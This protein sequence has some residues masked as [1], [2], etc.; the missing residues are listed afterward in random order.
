MEPPKEDKKDC[1]TFNPSLTIK[2]L[3]EETD[4]FELIDYMEI[5]E[6]FKK[7]YLI[8][9]LSSLWESLSSR[10]LLSKQGIPRFA[11]IEV[12]LRLTCSSPVSRGSS[13]SASSPSSALVR[14][15]FCR[16]RSSWT[17]HADCST[18]TSTTTWPSCSASSTSTTMASSRKRTSASCC[19]TCHLPKFCKR[20]K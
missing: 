11:F 19:P 16:R 3:P 17:A 12:A 9:Y 4:K 7:T 6:S 14:R 8:P 15:T 18:A 20:A 2:L 13:A 1:A 10:S 5:T